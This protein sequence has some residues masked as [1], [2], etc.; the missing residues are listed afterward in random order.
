MG[1]LSGTVNNVQT[2]YRL[3]DPNNTSVWTDGRSGEF[4]DIT[5]YQREFSA[6]AKDEWKVS[7]NLTLTPGIRWDYFGVPWARTRVDDS[8][9]WWRWIVLWNFRPGFHRLDESWCTRGPD[10]L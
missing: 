6:F 5:A 3:A 4:F 2:F 10:R 9:P 7:R 8:G 1:Y